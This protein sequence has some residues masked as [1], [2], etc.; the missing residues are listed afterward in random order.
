MMPMLTDFML[1]N[2]CSQLAEWHSL[3]AAFSELTVNVNVAGGDLAAGTLVKRVSVALLEA[4][5]APR[6]LTIEL[7]EDILMERLAQSMET[8]HELRDI[9]IKLSVDDFGT[10]YSSL[11]HL[12]TLPINSLK[13]D[14]SFVTNLRGGSKEAAIIRA[15]VVL[16]HSLE[17]TVVAEGIEDDWQLDQLKS[18]GCDIGQGYLLSKPLPH[19]GIDL[20]LHSVMNR[21]LASPSKRRTVSLH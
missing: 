6:H 18:L 21:K 4:G 19:D 9:G 14:R 1:K 7:T 3:D 11:S 16:G 5:I 17:K 10:G 20:L 8:L 15:I 2:A 12:S 13:I